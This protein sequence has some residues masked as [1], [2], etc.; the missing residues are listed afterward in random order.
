MDKK[1]SRTRTTGFR[2]FNFGGRSNKKTIAVIAIACVIAIVGTLTFVVGTNSVKG[3]AYE[4]L[5]GNGVEISE[6]EDVIVKYSFKTP[7]ANEWTIAVKYYDEPDV[8]YMYLH[9][10]KTIIYTGVAGM[11]ELKD[12][13]EYKHSEKIVN[14]GKY[15]LNITY[16]Y[17]GDETQT[18]LSFDATVAGDKNDIESIDR[19]EVLINT[20]YSDLVLE[21]DT[22]LTKSTDG[23]LS[24]IGEILVDTTGISKEEIDAVGILEGFKLIDKDGN[25]VE[26]YLPVDQK[27]VTE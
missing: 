27:D 26:V 10:D 12:F 8:F 24:I 3:R 17:G 7:F 13:S 9:R 1:V 2:L 14:N 4:H 11:E 18:R 20:R 19:H 23:I 5:R 22:H 6:I 15:T 25:E 21:N 16:S